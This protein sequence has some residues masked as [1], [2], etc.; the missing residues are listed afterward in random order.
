MPIFCPQGTESCMHRTVHV[1]HFFTGRVR[2]SKTGIDSDIRF[3]INQ[4]AERHELIESDVVGLHGV[5]CVIKGGRTP[6][7][8]ANAVIPAP[9]RKEI[10][11]RQSPETGMQLTK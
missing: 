9:V 3:H 1:F 5:P 2:I 8:R 7:A 6:V 10:A 4:P 11:T